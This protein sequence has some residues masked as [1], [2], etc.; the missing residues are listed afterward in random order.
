MP[1]W[2]NIS[3]STFERAGDGE[4]SPGWTAEPGDIVEA[5]QNPAP[6]SFEEAGGPTEPEPEPEPEPAADTPVDPGE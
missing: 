5:D 1:Q 4:G 6:G 2:K 3:E